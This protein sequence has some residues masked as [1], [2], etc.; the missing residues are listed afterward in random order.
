MKVAPCVIMVKA[1]DLVQKGNNI[2]PKE[3]WCDSSN[4]NFDKGMYCG[5][6]CFVK[7]NHIR[8]KFK[9]VR[10]HFVIPNVH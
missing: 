2:M 7:V 1:R 6:Q 8:P 3:I 5:Y 10:V 9:K 4:T